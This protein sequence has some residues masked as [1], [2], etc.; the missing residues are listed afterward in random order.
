MQSRLYTNPTNARASPVS[1]ARRPRPNGATNRLGL[2]AGGRSELKTLAQKPQPVTRLGS[3]NIGTMTGRSRELADVL[4]RRRV[5]IA[6]VQETKWTGSKAK[7]IGEGYKL[8]YNGDQTKRNGVGVVV[9][10]HLRD[11]VSKVDRVNSRLMSVQLN[12]VTNGSTLRVVSC[13]AP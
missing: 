2:P 10:E 3:L 4:K 7:D 1:D 5:D 13:Y 11:T 12:L 9:S 8:Y 6:C